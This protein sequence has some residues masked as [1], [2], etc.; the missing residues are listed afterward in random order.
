MLATAPAIAQKIDNPVAV[1][2]ALDKVTARISSL[3]IELDETVQF[4][5]LKI[6]PRVCYTRSPTEPPKTS[7][8]VQVDE[9]NLDGSEKRIFSSW[10]F[11]EDPGIN[12]VKHPVFDVWLTGCAQTR[13]KPNESVTAAS[14][15]PTRVSQ[16]VPLPIRKPYRRLPESRRRTLR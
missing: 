4:G 14:S 10:M 6:T 11:A 9:V 16:G 12:S 3:R 8:F 1:F 2:A 15:R 5:A 13:E 7:A